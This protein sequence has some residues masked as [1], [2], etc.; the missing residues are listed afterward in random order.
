MSSVF[1]RPGHADDEAVAADEEREQHLLN[2]VTLP[3]DQLPELGDDLLFTHLHP[4]REGDLVRRLQVDDFLRD[5]IH[6]ASLS[7]LNLRCSYQ[8]S[9]ISFQL[10][11]SGRG[12]KAPPYTLSS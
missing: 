5:A 2:S 6:T 9:A 12:L 10:L 8:L 7:I 4:V 11:S 1:A 3:D